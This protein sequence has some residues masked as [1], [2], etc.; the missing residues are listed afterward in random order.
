MSL[1][2]DVSIAPYTVESYSV[3]T[4]SEDGSWTRVTIDETVKYYALSLTGMRI[5][6]LESDMGVDP[7]DGA[8]PTEAK[9]VQSYNNRAM[10]IDKINGYELT[11]DY[12]TSF[13]WQRIGSSDEI[14]MNPNGGSNLTF[15]LSVVLTRSG[16][17]TT[18]YAAI[19]IFHE[20]FGQRV[21][22]NSATT[23]WTIT[24]DWPAVI[25]AR[26]AID[27][28]PIGKFTVRAFR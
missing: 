12:T 26:P 27:F 28:T 1:Y 19:P 16:G 15:P 22:T 23:T 21:S 8:F 9:L 10:V 17:N 24:L 14:T 2:D 18:M 3:T 7:T 20:N 4:S 6:T 13:A 25:I 5:A 11:R